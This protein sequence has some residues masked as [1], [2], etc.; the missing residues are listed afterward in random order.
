MS[1]NTKVDVNFSELMSRLLAL[2]SPKERDVIERR[3]S[4]AGHKKETLD[5]IGKSY[6]ITRER[7]RQIEAVALKKL[8]RISMDPSMREIHSLAFE[9]LNTSGKVML[10]DRLV[11]EMLKNMSETKNVDTNAVK[12]AMRVSDR[13]VKQDKNQ[14]YN[15]FWRTSDL[16]LMEVKGLIK[17]IQKTMRKKGD[18]VSTEELFEKLNK[19]YPLNMVESV[20]EVDWSFKKT[21]EGWGL[22]AW[23]H[24][25]P[26]SIKDKIMI[27]FKEESKPLHFT[28]IVNHVLGDFDAKKMV[29]HQAIHN[30]LIRHEDFVLVG[31]GMYALKDWGLAAGTVCD[32]IVQV[33]KEND[34]PMKRQDIINAVLAKRDIRIG[35]ISLNLQKYE[36]FKRV[37]RAVYEYAPE[38]D[39]RRRN[40]AQA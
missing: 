15:A 13:M 9:I 31:R 40:K 7:V 18:V 14:F 39:K 16:S 29:T 3:F 35:T 20:L 11:S 32:L 23:R 26:K 12:L 25:N 6:S 28:E 2:L 5:K 38:L 33:L 19:D 10:E 36:F 34:G 22:S 27:V 21:E 1:I 30:E 17:A 24:I 8:T 4:L 37:G